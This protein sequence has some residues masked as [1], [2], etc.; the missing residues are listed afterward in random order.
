MYAVAL[1]GLMAMA[2]AEMRF[3]RHE[4]AAYPGGYQVAVADVNGDGRPDVIALSTDGNR[5]DW[6]ENP[7][8]KRR[9]VAQVERPIDLAVHDLDG[10]GRPGIALAYGF[11]FGDSSRGGDIAWL[12][13]KA[14][15]DE[16]WE[17]HPIA[18]D[19]VVHRL[20]WADLD[21]DG[22]KELVHVP[23]FGPGSQGARAPR[24]AHLWAFTV[25]PQ[26]PSGKLE[27]WKI[28]ET[29]T[30][31]H[32]VY[33]GDLDG[34]RRDEV[35]TASYEGIFRFDLEGPLA[36]GRWLK[37]HI[38]DGAPPVSNEPGA[39]RGSSE[40]AVG[41]LP[42]GRSFLAAIEPWHGHQVVVYLPQDGSDGWQRCVLDETLREGHALVVADLDRDGRDEL[43]AGWRGAGG[44]LTWYDPDDGSPSDYRAV[45][46]DRQ[47][48]VEG[49]AAADING[50][51]RLDL[52]ANAGRSNKLVWYENRP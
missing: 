33:I 10:D 28:D 41:R 1:A 6:F 2:Q 45:P 8:W 24:P 26:C 32:G 17:I 4:I 31:V 36:E 34:D 22:R 20:R 35:L 14:N 16:P 40:V 13:P 44:G 7:T 46:L 5:V 49:L 12:R 47:I 42:D 51:G 9:P 48:A 25:P 27:V 3:V 50:D 30:V 38:A 21:G 52:V 11:Y 39:A 23:L 29:L 43:V 19:P 15:L 18:K 37:K